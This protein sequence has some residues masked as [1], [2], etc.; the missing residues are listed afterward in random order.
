MRI[1][2]RVPGDVK[3]LEQL[4]EGE[5]NADRRDRLRVALLALRGREKLEIAELLGMAKS[6]VEHWA[7]TYRDAGIEALRGKTRRGGSPKIRGETARLLKDRIDAGPRESDGVCTLRGK[8]IRRIAK[9]ELGVDVG[10]SS[11]YRALERMGYSCLSPRPRHEK[12][13]PQAQRKFKEESAPL[14]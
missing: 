8:D 2:E 12:Q 3:R 1:I 11:V 13:D 14:L 9:E 5:K 7:Y 6:T 10:L 4:I